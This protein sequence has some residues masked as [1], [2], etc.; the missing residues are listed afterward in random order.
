MFPGVS[1]PV[2]SVSKRRVGVTRTSWVGTG[3]PAGR[4]LDAWRLDL[5]MRRYSLYGQARMHDAVEQ[6]LGTR[7]RYGT[8]ARLE[9]CR[10]PGGKHSETLTVWLC[11]THCFLAVAL[12]TAYPDADTPRAL[13]TVSGGRCFYLE[14]SSL[15]GA[16]LQLDQCLEARWTG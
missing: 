12:G 15:T 13:H 11:R 10:Y 5:Q 14:Q 16:W 3:N 1:I 8:P 4:Q 2:K 9:P 6:F 7:L